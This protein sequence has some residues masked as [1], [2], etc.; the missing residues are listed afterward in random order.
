MPESITNSPATEQNGKATAVPG[1]GRHRGQHSDND[2]PENNEKG[3]HGRHRR[4]PKQQHKRDEESTTEQST[5][6]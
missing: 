3:G 1:T 4:T 2:A 6:R 5:T